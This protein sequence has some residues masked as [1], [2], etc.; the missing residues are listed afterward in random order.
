MK[1]NKW[2]AAVP[3]ALVILGCSVPSDGDNIDT[4]TGTFQP[5]I[6]ASATVA[7]PSVSIAP[8]KP[9]KPSIDSGTWMVGEDVEPG[10]YKV[11]GVAGD[12]C[13]WEIS[14]DGTIAEN[15]FGGG[16]PQVSLKNGDQFTTSGC[17]L[18]EK[19]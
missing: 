15:Y 19:K 4:D 17:P 3:V 13:Y 5:N 12:T 16:K 10:D 11:V 2:I 9:S 14:R 7:P 1:F 6:S 18:F 8:S